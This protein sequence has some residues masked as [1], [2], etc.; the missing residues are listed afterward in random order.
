MRFVECMVLDTVKSLYLNANEVLIR[1]QM[2]GRNLNNVEPD[3]YDRVS[4]VFNDATF[5]P[6]SVL[7]QILAKSS[8]NQL[9]FHYWTITHGS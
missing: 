1:Y 3:F 9:H 4:A 5:I 2:D 7:F 6:M 8:P